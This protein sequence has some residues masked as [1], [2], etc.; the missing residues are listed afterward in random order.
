MSKINIDFETVRTKTE[1]LKKLIE[2]ELKGNIPS[3]Y[4]RALTYAQEFQGAGAETLQ[5]TI[6]MEKQNT[7]KLTHFLLEMLAFIQ[8]SADAFEKVD[9]DHENIIC[10]F[11]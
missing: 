6:E 1:E 8:E 10:K 4:E 5:L 7:E 3:A 11:L 9:T 2:T